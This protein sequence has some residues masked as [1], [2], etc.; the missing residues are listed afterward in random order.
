TRNLRCRWQPRCSDGEGLFETFDPVIDLAPVLGRLARHPRLLAVLAEL[1]GEPA[2]LIND[3]LIFKPPGA[4]C[5]DRH[6]DSIAWASSPRRCMAPAVAIDSCDEGNGCT[7]AY[8]GY[9]KRGCLTPEDGDYHPLPDGT[10][11]EATAF[12]LELQPG[13]VAFFGCFVPHRSAPN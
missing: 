1:Y 4:K 5:Y 10:V 6:Q 8:P 11:D 3:K 9:H 7:V 2:K 12:P 13:D